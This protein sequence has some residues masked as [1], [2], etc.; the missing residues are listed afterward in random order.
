MH[1]VAS[2]EDQVGYRSGFP[3]DPSSKSHRQLRC[4]FEGSATAKSMGQ[5]RREPPRSTL[6]TGAGE[7]GQPNEKLHWMRY[8]G[9]FL[10]KVM[11]KDRVSWRSEQPE[12]HA[13]SRWRHSDPGPRARR[14]G[15][16]V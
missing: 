5:R 6:S 4:A 15:H 11:P 13:K 1:S 16:V 2:M 8:G 12:T 7:S 14:L 10:I 3:S 9:Q